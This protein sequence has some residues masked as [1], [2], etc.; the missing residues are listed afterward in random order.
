MAERR[1]EGEGVVEMVAC[2]PVSSVALGMFVV[3]AAMGIVE[4]KRIPCRQENIV[5]TNKSFRWPQWSDP[6]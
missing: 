4:G 2:D 3:L 5:L 6:C 1:Q